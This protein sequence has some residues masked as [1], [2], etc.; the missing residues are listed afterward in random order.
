MPPPPACLMVK[1]SQ[2]QIRLNMKD[3][4][5]KLTVYADDTIFFVKGAQSLKRVGKVMKTIQ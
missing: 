2:C 1:K 3:I 5:L 4:K